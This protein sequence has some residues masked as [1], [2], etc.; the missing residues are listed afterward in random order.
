MKA[1]K[2]LCR[3]LFSLVFLC[4]CCASI[5]A[6]RKGFSVLGCALQGK[7]PGKIEHYLR[8][9]YPNDPEHIREALNQKATIEKYRAALTYNQFYLAATYLPALA[10]DHD[11]TTMFQETIKH[12]S[13][14]ATENTIQNP[15]SFFI[16]IDQIIDH[17][18]QNKNPVNLLKVLIDIGRYISFNLNNLPKSKQ[19]ANTNYIAN[20]A[21]I[22]QSKLFQPTLFIKALEISQTNKDAC[23]DRN[24]LAELTVLWR[25]HWANNVVQE[26]VKK[27]ITGFYESRVCPNPNLLV[28]HCNDLSLD[29]CKPQ[30]YLFAGLLKQAA[31][32][33]D[34][35]LNLFLRKF[36]L[37][38]RYNNLSDDTL[39]EFLNIISDTLFKNTYADLDVDTAIDFYTDPITS[40]WLLDDSRMCPNPNFLVKLCNNVPLDKC[41]SHLVLFTKLLQQ[42]VTKKNFEANTFLRMFI[43]TVHD[44]NLSDDT[45]NRFL[46]IISN[47]LIE[48]KYVDLDPETMFS[49]YNEARTRNWLLTQLS[50]ENAPSEHRARLFVKLITNT[51]DNVPLPLLHHLTKNGVTLTKEEIQK[52]ETALKSAWQK[53]RLTPNILGY[54]HW[55]KL[56]KPLSTVLQEEWL[57]ENFMRYQHLDFDGLFDNINIQLWCQQGYPWLTA[58]E[59]PHEAFRQL[60]YVYEETHLYKE[61]NKYLRQVEGNPVRHVFLA[62][63]GLEGNLFLPR[64]ACPE[65]LLAFLETI[66][67]ELDAEELSKKDHFEQSLLNNTFA[68]FATLAALLDYTGLASREL[69][70]Y[71]PKPHNACLPLTPPMQ[72][73]PRMSS[74]MVEFKYKLEL[75]YALKQQKIAA[76]N[77]QH[78]R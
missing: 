24:Q 29:K 69:K 33:E 56:I 60:K 48:N 13:E 42:S 17:T 62:N 49:A 64:K 31:T 12:W 39:N 4:C 73:Q 43:S 30:C 28:K 5:F 51:P 70:K 72:E 77:Q 75:L 25:Y 66:S 6:G 35:L 78:K 74:S 16:F 46:S 68:Q 1:M 71:L 40:K 18:T 15:T 57:L 3:Y 50:P 10:K 76:Y 32:H 41:Q 11:T 61:T 58:W 47:S 2:K 59:D 20:F 54:L 27:C 45:F 26:F 52:C 34:F 37:A 65:T 19:E 53:R 36:I 38:T 63:L 7:Q 55:A 67:K 23:L 14:K 21:H 9:N 44:N 22:F 8:K